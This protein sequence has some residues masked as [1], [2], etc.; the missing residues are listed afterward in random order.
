MNDFQ[1]F[2]NRNN[3]AGIAGL[4]VGITTGAGTFLLGV[5]EWWVWGWGPWSW[6]YPQGKSATIHA[7]WLA[8]VGHVNP[9]YKGDLG[10]WGSF[11]AGLRGSHQYDAFV[12]SFWVPFLIGASI[13]LLAAWLVVRASNRKGAAYLRGGRFD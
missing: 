7:Y 10:T 11:E 8:L 4:L 13:G 6:S 12:A 1:G 3:G 2:D 5:R 9:S